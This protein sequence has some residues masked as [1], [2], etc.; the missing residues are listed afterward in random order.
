[1]A[2]VNKRVGKNNA[3]ERF[4]GL[5]RAADG[6]YKSAARLTRR[7]APWTLQRRLSGTPACGWPRRARPTRRP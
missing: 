4:T 5:Y 2:Y 3:T 1:M 6:S 7:S